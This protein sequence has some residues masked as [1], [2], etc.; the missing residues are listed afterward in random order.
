[1]TARRIR[2]GV[3]TNVTTLSAAARRAC[4][5]YEAAARGGHAPSQH[6]VAFALAT[7]GLGLGEA[8]SFC[9]VSFLVPGFGFGLEARRGARCGEDRIE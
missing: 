6:A 7:G 9:L 1:V 8:R 5:R 4:V 2:D 3:E